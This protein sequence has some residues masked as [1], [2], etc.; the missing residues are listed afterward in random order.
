MATAVTV[1]EA[2][3][4]E[5]ALTDA[6][7]SQAGTVGGW[8][9]LLG[10]VSPTLKNALKSLG[11]QA[12]NKRYNPLTTRQQ[13]DVDAILR[14]GFQRTSAA[15]PRSGAS[16]AGA[17]DGS[18]IDD[19]LHETHGAGGEEL[20]EEEAERQR[21]L[22]DEAIRRAAERSGETRFQRGARQV[23][24]VLDAVGRWRNISIAVGGAG[25]GGFGVGQII[26]IIREY[27]RPTWNVKMTPDGKVEVTDD[28]GTT[29]II[30]PN[31]GTITKVASRGS[32]ISGPMGSYGAI[33]EYGKF[34]FPKYSRY[35]Y[36]KWADY[37]NEAAR[38]T[39]GGQMNQPI[40]QPMRPTVVRAGATGSRV[41]PIHS[42]GLGGK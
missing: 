23:G 30:D 19:Q 21:L 27:G 31:S 24:D 37:T 12:F 22:P 35:N 2:A 14:G 32:G 4:G 17:H 1:I 3:I 20:T 41:I 34:R 8:E 38:R 9:S 16:A 13:A 7:I 33:K 39:L 6:M 42:S 10:V 25:A 11:R 5:E 18:N 28:E 36:A 29:K 40:A 26:R 15:P